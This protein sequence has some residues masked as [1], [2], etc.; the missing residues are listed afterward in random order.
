MLG[1]VGLKN[2]N[3][4]RAIRLPLGRI[5]V[6]IGPNGTGKSSVLQALALLKQS[7]NHE[8]LL[9]EGHAIDLGD[10][11]DVVHRPAR[12]NV[13]EFRLVAPAAEVDIRW[14]GSRFRYRQPFD[15]AVYKAR[16]DRGGLLDHDVRLSGQQPIR[17]SWSRV[18]KSEVRPRQIELGPVTVLLAVSGNVA[19]V[20]S[21]SGL[22]HSPDA[23][24]SSV[25]ATRTAFQRHLRPR[26]RRSVVH[27]S[28]P[29]SEA[30]ISPRIPFRGRLSTTF[31]P[32]EDRKARRRAF[33]APLL[34]GANWKKRFLSC[35]SVS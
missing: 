12:E 21:V 32:T 3:A 30:L 15:Q 14:R 24:P 10:Y 7:R 35:Q 34:T 11:D 33:S 26:A 18:G 20:L 19:Q 23:D 13:I 25:E 31:S 16:F 6:L 5:T 17:A 29:L 2:F 4:L 9:T 22:E 8:Q 28:C 1:E 27:M